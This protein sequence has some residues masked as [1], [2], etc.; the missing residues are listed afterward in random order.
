[1]KYRHALDSRSVLII[2]SHSPTG[3]IKVARRSC[4]GCWLVTVRNTQRPVMSFAWKTACQNCVKRYCKT[5]KSVEVGK[6]KFYT[7]ALKELSF[8]FERFF[9]FFFLFVTGTLCQQDIDG[10]SNNGS[11]RIDD[12]FDEKL[13]STGREE[14]LVLARRFR[15][16]FADFFN[17]QPAFS[18]QDYHVTHS[19]K[20]QP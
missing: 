18:M 6:S 7:F 10:L 1:M 3:S 16:R 20:S 15:G 5:T 4:S 2:V 9:P 8:Y 19:D 13:T 12:D 17:S 14:L 11:I